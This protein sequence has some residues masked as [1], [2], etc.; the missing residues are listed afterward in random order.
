[1]TPSTRI[2]PDTGLAL[3][4]TD[5]PPQAVTPM[6][7]VILAASTGTVFEYYDFLLYGTLAT[8]FGSLFFPPGNDTAA[9]L[10]SLATFGAG[11]AVR[12]LGA[13]IFGRLGDRVGRKRTFLITIMLMGASTALVGVLPTFET[14]GWWAPALLVSLRLVQGLALGGEFGGA[15]IYIAEHCGKDNR[16]FFTS[17][18]QTTGT[19]GLVLSLLV[20]LACRAALGEEDFRAWGWRLPFL[21]SVVLLGL[22]VYVRMK[23]SESPLFAELKRTGGLSESPILESLMQRENLGRMLAA[24]I[25]A[26]AMAISWYTAQFYSLVFLQTALLID[27]STTSIIIVVALLIGVPIYAAAGALSDRIGRRPVMLS[28]M[29]LAA[30]AVMPAYRGLLAVG[31][32][33]LAQAQASAPITVHAEPTRFDPFA[34]PAKLDAATRARD[35]LAKRGISYANAA[36]RPDAPLSI[37]VADRRLDGFDR[38]ALSGALAAAG[39][40][41]QAA[42]PRLTALADV[43]STHLKLVGWILLMI[44]GAGLTCGPGAAWLSEIFP[45]RIRYTSLSVPYHLTSAWFGGFMPLTAAWLVARTGNVLSGLWYP[46]V[47]MG[48]CF[49]LSLFLMKESRG[50]DL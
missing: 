2:V 25:V 6:P 20:I 35:F 15:A 31:N 13:L 40:P 24:I 46:I 16:G 5:A 4:E 50:N 41:T 9:L 7:R 26:A 49:V 21:L 30:L 38:E 42:T 29:L 45:T 27:S 47:V 14:I 37:Q 17:W 23:L 34:D 18:I 22:S 3:G 19:I 28:G 39:Y 43:E 44:I 10:G 8:F 12:P 11:F 33:Q 48:T 36:P 32:P 1:M